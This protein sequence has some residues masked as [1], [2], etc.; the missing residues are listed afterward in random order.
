MVARNYQKVIGNLIQ[1]QGTFVWR[2]FMYA[3]SLCVR[4]RNYH[5]IDLYHLYNFY[6]IFLFSQMTM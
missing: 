4:I 5:L 3:A 2:W 6:D 1:R